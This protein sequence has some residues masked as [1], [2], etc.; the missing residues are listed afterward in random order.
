MYSLKPF[1]EKYQTKV[2]RIGAIK[3]KSKIIVFLDTL[4]K[5]LRLN[6]SLND[7]RMT[8]TGISKAAGTLNNVA[9]ENIIPAPSIL[10]VFRLLESSIKN[11]KMLKPI[12]NTSELAI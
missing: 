2:R 11:A 3:P 5:P 4:S 12:M 7:Q 9:I 1:L 10:F 8:I 6:F